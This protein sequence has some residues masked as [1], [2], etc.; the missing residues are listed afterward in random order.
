MGYAFTTE[1][2]EYIRHGDKPQRAKLYRPTGDGPFP[3]VL[4][5]HGGAWCN[6]DLED[7]DARDKVLAASGLF[8]AA[9]NFRHAGDGYPTSL[10]DINYAMR[11]FKANAGKFNA[12]AEC[13]RP[14]GHVERRPPGDAGGDA[15]E[16]C[17]L[18]RDRVAGGRFGGRCHGAGDRDAVAGDQSAVSLPSCAPAAR[19]REPAGWVG[20]I[21]ERH[22]PYWKTEAAMAE[23]NPIADPGAGRE[24]ADAADAVDPGPAGPDARL[25]RSGIAGRTE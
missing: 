14:V 13:G 1:E 19:H 17:A 18:R 22:E 11:W 8:V 6:G 7:C 23:G 3:I 5:L 9:L 10:Q 2:I 25:S 20:N 12:R 15:A 4:D 16:R 24:S 21:P